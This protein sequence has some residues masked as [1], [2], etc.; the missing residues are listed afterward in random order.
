MLWTVA[1]QA[2]L[3]MGFSRQFLSFFFQAISFFLQV[4]IFFSPG[5]LPDPGIQ[6][7]SLASPELAGEFFTIV[8]P[9]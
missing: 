6:P 8:P 4:A 3:S 1:G 9:G 2:P 7:A 5:D